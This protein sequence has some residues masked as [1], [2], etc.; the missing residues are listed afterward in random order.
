MREKFSRIKKSPVGAGLL[1][2]G[3]SGEK[4]SYA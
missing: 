3:L 4:V 2:K 1:E